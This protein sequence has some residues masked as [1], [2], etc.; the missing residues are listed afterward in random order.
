M[1]LL[2][3][4]FELGL[5]FSSYTNPQVEGDMFSGQETQDFY[6]LSAIALKCNLINLR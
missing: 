2:L 3:N 5:E 1:P 6:T 4:I